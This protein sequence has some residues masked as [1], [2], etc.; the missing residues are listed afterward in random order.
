MTAFP[1]IQQ[2]V[3]ECEKMEAFIAAHPKNQPDCPEELR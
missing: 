3:S 2:V 1:K